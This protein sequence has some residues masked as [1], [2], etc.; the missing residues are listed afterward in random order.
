MRLS[1]ADRGYY[2]FANAGQDGVFAGT[3]YKLLDVGAY[4]YLGKRYKLNTI[5]CHGSY[6]GRCNYFRVYRYL[7]SLEYIAAGKIY[8]CSL[9]EFK[10]YVRFVGRYERT[11]YIRYIAACQVV[12]F[13]L[14]GCKIQ[15]GLL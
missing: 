15:T 12:C 8:R 9:F 3:T 1:G 6:L 11:Y 4:G 10:V 7:Y 5:G 13:E 2:T 14:A